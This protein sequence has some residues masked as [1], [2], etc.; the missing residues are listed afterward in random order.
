MHQQT[1]LTEKK[2]LKKNHIAMLCAA[3]LAACSLCGC[4]QGS[5]AAGASAE[6]STAASASEPRSLSIVTTIFPE[7]DWVMNILGENPAGAEVTMLLDNGVDLHNGRER[8]RGC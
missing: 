8:Y 6:T 3:V 1:R 7:Y 4:G 2:T 5:T